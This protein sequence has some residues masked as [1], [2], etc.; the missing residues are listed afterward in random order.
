[1]GRELNPRVH[2]IDL[3]FVSELRPGL[4]GWLLLD[5][6]A[7]AVGM[8]RTGSISPSLIFV[9]AAQGIYVADA[10][11]FEVGILSIVRRFFFSDRFFR[12]P[13]CRQWT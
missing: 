12:R 4:I 13:F 1:M 3:K 7:C 11:W 5:L 6:S 8:K 2:G 10:L 9:T